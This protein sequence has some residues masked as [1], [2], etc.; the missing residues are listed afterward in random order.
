MKRTCL[1]LER[2]ETRELPS[3]VLA[4]PAA[5]PSVNT[6]T[7]T[8]AAHISDAVKAQWFGKAAS[9]TACEHAHNAP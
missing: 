4:N 1:T 5:L 6:G 9:E 2:L 3:C 7:A 8:A